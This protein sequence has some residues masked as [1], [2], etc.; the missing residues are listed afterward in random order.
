MNQKG[1]KTQRTKG[2]IEADISEAIIKFEKEYMGRGAAE[3]KTDMVA[4]M[5]KASIAAGADGLM[6]EAHVEPSKAWSDAAQ[7]ITPQQLKEIVDAC[8]ELRGP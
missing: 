5:S 2:Q 8:N 6:L 3:T 4:A 1:G 7:T